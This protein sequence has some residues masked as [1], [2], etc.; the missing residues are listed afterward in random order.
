MADFLRVKYEYPKLKQSEMANE[1]G[2]S[3]STLQRYKNETNMLSPYR[4]HPNKTNK[5]TKKIKNTNFDNISL[6]DHDIE[7]PQTTSKDLNR[8]QMVGK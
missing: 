3:S 4:I 8:V 7:W 1:I 5:R 2:W 6:R